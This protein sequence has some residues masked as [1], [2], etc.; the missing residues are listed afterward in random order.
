[1]SGCGTSRP[2]PRLD[3]RRRVSSWP[4][5]ALFTDTIPLRSYDVT[6]AT[7]TRERHRLGRPARAGGERSAARYGAG[8]TPSQREARGN[9]LGDRGQ[10]RP[11]LRD[12]PADR[13]E[14]PIRSWCSTTTGSC[15]ARGGRGCTRFR[16]ASRSVRTATSGPP[17][18]TRRRSTN[19]RRWERSCS[20]S[21]SAAFPIARPTSAASPT[22]RSR[23]RAPATCSSPTATATAACSNTTPRESRCRSSGPRVMGPVSSTTRTASPSGP[24]GTSTSPTGKTVASSGHSSRKRARRCRSLERG[25]SS[26]RRSVRPALN[27]CWRFHIELRLAMV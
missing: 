12:P 23:P 9:F 26:G 19:S 6:P 17:T 21:R 11:H 3:S 25:S 13:A 4:V 14:A 1:M 8:R 20:R 7:P 10:G 27:V 18:P 15:C 2:G 16:T 24:T 22:S 5:V